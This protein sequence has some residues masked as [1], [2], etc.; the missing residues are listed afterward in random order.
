MT[1]ALIASVSMAH[2]PEMKPC[3]LGMIP[4][5]ATLLLTGCLSFDS[6]PLFV[7]PA[8]MIAE[9]TASLPATLR[10]LGLQF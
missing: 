5:L 3:T 8:D 4:L 9:R 10:E 1:P 6:R 7:P 2:C